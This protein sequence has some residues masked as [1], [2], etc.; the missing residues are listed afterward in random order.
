MFLTYLLFLMFLMYVM[1]WF[2]YCLF[3][4]LYFLN[5]ISPCS[6]MVVY[7]DSSTTWPSTSAGT[8][9][10][11]GLLCNHTTGSSTAASLASTMSSALT[12]GPGVLPLT[13]WSQRNCFGNPHAAVC[14]WPL[15]NPTSFQNTTVRAPEL[16]PF[17]EYHMCCF[18]IWK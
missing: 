15:E 1:Y 16:Q 5:L 11:L 9:G 13:W 6:V 8:P 2:V 17:P 10:P 7:G 4:F 18:R 14:G 12:P 3:L